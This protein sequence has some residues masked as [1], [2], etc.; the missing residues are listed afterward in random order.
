MKVSKDRPINKVAALP[1]VENIVR[2]V[3]SIEGLDKDYYKVF[4][5]GF[6]K[7]ATTSLYSLFTQ[8]GYEAMDGPHWRK[9]ADWHIH[10][11][12][13][14]F[15]DGPPEDFRYLDKTFPRSKFILNVRD[16]REWLDSRIEH[17]RY[18]LEDPRYR[19]RP[20]AKKLPDVNGVMKWVER[21]DEHHLQVL[22]YF[23]SRKDDLL[24]VNFIKDPLAVEKICDFLRKP[25][26]G[27]DKPYN[28]STPK[29]RE[30][31]T[32][33][34]QEVIETALDKL[35]VKA[36]ERDNDIYCPSL[37]GSGEISVG[38]PPTTDGL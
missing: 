8:L 14:T 27:V 22:D 3:R 7:T 9:T 30:P 20:G 17:V 18:R 1:Q 31:G 35:G 12:F 6:N 23:S 10:Y 16:L 2:T 38:H 32:V 25:L 29:N 15:S 21:R 34:N 28:R 19:N 26:A 24:V 4:A 33:L 11:Q 37:R 13:Q 36:S 5:I